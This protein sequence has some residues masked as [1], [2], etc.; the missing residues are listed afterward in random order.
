[1]QHVFQPEGEKD[2][3]IYIVYQVSDLY[4]FII[5][6][7]EIAYFYFYILTEYLDIQV[8]E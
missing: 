5:A 6:A 4:F 1:M 8:Y 7:A 3:L 2:S